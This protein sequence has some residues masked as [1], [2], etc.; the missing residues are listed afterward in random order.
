MGQFTDGDPIV[1]KGEYSDDPSVPCPEC[2]DDAWRSAEN[3]TVYYD[4]GNGRL[5]VLSAVQDAYRREG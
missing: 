3:D 5:C 4:H 2:G 1:L